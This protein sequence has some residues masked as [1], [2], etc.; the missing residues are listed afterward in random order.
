[1]DVLAFQVQHLNLLKK[2]LA[3]S[4]EVEMERRELKLSVIQVETKR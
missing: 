1:M 3:E 4:K 2:R